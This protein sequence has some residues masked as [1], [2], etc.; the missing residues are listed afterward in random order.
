VSDCHLLEDSFGLTICSL[1]AV[2]ID[3]EYTNRY[4]TH[5]G[6]YQDLI[7]FYHASKIDVP[8]TYNDFGGGKSFVNGTVSYDT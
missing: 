1:A 4:P 3:N 6:Y 5:A 8:L 7:D 2:Q